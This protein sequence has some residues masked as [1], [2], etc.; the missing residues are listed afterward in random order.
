MYQPAELKKYAPL[1]WSSG[2]GV[3]VW[4]LFCACVSGDIIAVQRLLQSDPSLVR[5]QYAYRTPLYFAVR[6]NQVAVAQLLLKSGADPLSL[7]VNDS[8]LAICGDRGYADMQQL[9]SAHYATR[10]N[11]SSRGEIVA[12]AI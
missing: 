6:E 10:L 3:D 4:E 11:A 2:R 1:V 7:A 5:C 9:L 8:L 12:A